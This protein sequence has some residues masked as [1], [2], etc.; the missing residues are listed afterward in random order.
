MNEWDKNACGV[1]NKHFPEGFVDNRSIEDVKI[2]EIRQYNQC[3]FFAGI[4]GFSVAFERYAP[5]VNVW[6]GGFP[7]QDL[8]VAGKR[9]GLAGSRSGLYFTFHKL[10]VSGLPRWI[11]LENVPGLLISN[12][13]KDFAIVI[14]GLTG[15]VPEVPEG[16]W[17]NAGF[18]RGS[19]YQVAYRILDAQFFGVPQ[20]R[21]R[22]FIVGS[23]GN[24]SAAEVLFESESM[25]GDTPTGRKAGKDASTTTIINLANS[26][27]N[28]NN[29]NQTSV[30]DTLDTWGSFAIASRS[31]AQ[32]LTVRNTQN[33]AGGGIKD[34]STPTLIIMAHGQANA[35]IVND[36]SP[37]LT[38]NHEAPILATMVNGIRRL[39]PTECERLQGF[40]DGWTDGQADTQRYKQLGNAVAIPV[41][42]W[43][44]RR[45]ILVDKAG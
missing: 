7:C 41:V 30:M 19:V 32:S 2:E 31:V 12:E 5:N 22:V 11:V 15:I 23:F 27:A 35:E 18:F 38:T 39:T 33:N 29:V 45:I 1:L 43:I 13:G 8:S 28:Q 16:G 10:I 3:H 40:P 37:S 4:G 34:R 20:R 9:A 25:S 36:G 26:G 14:G 6:T 24:G 44:A 17:G 42:E 21:R